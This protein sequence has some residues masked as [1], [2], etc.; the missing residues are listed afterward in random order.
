[1]VI[2]LISLS[3]SL[4]SRSFLN[5]IDPAALSG[6]GLTTAA[7]GDGDVRLP[8]P[9][10]KEMGAG[11]EVRLNC[12]ELP[13]LRGV[14]FK[15]AELPPL[16]AAEILCKPLGAPLTRLV[17]DVGLLAIAASYVGGGGRAAGTL[18]G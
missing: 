1:M 4:F 2:F 10:P 13:E 5:R 8:P 18:C 6:S 15:N 11:G 3:F 12:T 14:R 16:A 9:L 17:G 7:V